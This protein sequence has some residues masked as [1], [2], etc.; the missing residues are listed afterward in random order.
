[1]KNINWWP[2][3]FE[4]FSSRLLNSNEVQ[5]KAL[6]MHLKSCYSIAGQEFVDRAR[7]RIINLIETVLTQPSFNIASESTAFSRRE[8][9]INDEEYKYYDQRGLF[10]VNWVH[11]KMVRS[12]LVFGPS[13]SSA[14]MLSLT[15]MHAAVRVGATASLT[16][17]ARMSP[18]SSTPRH[19]ASK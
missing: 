5:E 19:E 10:E 7:C 1:M 16:P 18:I 13:Q 2:K 15:K 12:S 3:E 11:T 8:N 14:T 9:T 17:K 4:P 6:Q